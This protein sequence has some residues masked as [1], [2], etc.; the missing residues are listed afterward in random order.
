MSVNQTIVGFIV[1]EWRDSNSRP[2]APKAGVQI[3]HPVKQ[4]IENKQNLSI[5]FT[6]NKPLF[7]FRLQRRES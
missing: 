4:L 1:S 2:P 3:I 7:F 5:K 6:I